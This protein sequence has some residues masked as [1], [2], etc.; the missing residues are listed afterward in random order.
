[1]STTIERQMALFGFAGTRV[2]VIPR[3]CLALACGQLLRRVLAHG[4]VSL[5][6]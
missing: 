5:E 1:M 6:N 2:G 3:T 4:P